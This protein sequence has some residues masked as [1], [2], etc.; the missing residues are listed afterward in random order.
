MLT[1]VKYNDINFLK[2]STERL[3]VVSEASGG[4]IAAVVLAAAAGGGTAA[5]SD[6]I[7]IT[8]VSQGGDKFQIPKKI[9]CSHVWG[10]RLVSTMVGIDDGENCD[11]EGS[12]DD[13]NQEEIPLLQVSTDVLR[14]V[15][16]ATTDPT[17]SY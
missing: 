17:P 13:N 14:E 11:S 2:M 5:S 6:E 16:L 7:I 4:D 8:L 1:N 15:Y 12:S 3:P 10:S 9:I